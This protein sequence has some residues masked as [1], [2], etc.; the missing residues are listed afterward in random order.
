MAGHARFGTRAH[1]HMR[2]ST[3]GHAAPL[4][5]HTQTHNGAVV[6]PSTTVL[7][8]HNVSHDEACRAREGKRPIG[9]GGGER[10]ASSHAG[11]RSRCDLRRARAALVLPGRARAA[12]EAKQRQRVAGVSCALPRTGLVLEPQHL[13]KRCDASRLPR[14]PRRPLRHDCR[15]YLRLARRGM[16][17]RNRRHRSV[18]DSTPV[19]GKVAVR[20]AG[21]PRK[22]GNSVRVRKKKKQ[23]K[24]HDHPP[25]HGPPKASP[26]RRSRRTAGAPIVCGMGGAR[27]WRGEVWAQQ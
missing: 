19:Q 1:T 11:A 3:G 27:V 20:R 12:D 22:S 2:A 25:D 4:S 5:E 16:F 26:Q 6:P 23:R 18:R 10:G 9:T 13:L 14:R 7:R 24:R 8:L 17:R 21:C 15:R